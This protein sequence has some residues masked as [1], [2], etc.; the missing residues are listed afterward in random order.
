MKKLSIC[1]LGKVWVYCLKSLKKPSIY[2]L[3]KTP[4][5]PSVTPSVGIAFRMQPIPM[6]EVLRH[7]SDGRFLLPNVQDLGMAQET[8]TN[9]QLNELE[10][11]TLMINTNRLS[12]VLGHLQGVLGDL[13]AVQTQEFVRRQTIEG[14]GS[15]EVVATQVAERALDAEFSDLS[16]SHVDVELDDFGDDVDQE[17]P[18]EN[19]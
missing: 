10:L 19:Q 15:L 7:I 18:G 4:S 1:P 9:V 6:S 5:A 17:G 3:G 16:L 8:R 2:P 12:G 11:S 13:Q 14:S